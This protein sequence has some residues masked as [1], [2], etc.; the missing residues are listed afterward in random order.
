MEI[1]NNENGQKIFRIELYKAI[2][3]V[4]T[5]ILVMGIGGFFAGFRFAI[6][7][8]YRILAAENAIIDIKTELTHINNK[9]DRLIELHIVP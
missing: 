5:T 3:G 2:L 9:L 8:H 1:K 4:V 7:D 6:S